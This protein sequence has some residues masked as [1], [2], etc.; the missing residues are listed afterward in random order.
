MQK[1]V[2]SITMSLDGFIA[3]PEISKKQ[4]MGKDGVRLHD[5]IFAGKTDID[6]NLLN[7]V[8]KNSG[9]VIVGARTYNTA[10]EDAWGGE[11]PFTVPAF[12]LCHQLPEIV[13]EGFTF[14]TDGI[15]SGLRQARTAADSKDVWVMGGANIIQQYLKA[16]LVDQL[17]IHI[18]PVLFVNGTRLFD[19]LALEKI[20]L[21]KISTIDTPA[22]THIRYEIVNDTK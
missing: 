7:E 5:W 10:I 6:S 3:G 14:V 21:R 12:V 4:P 13:V 16:K 17:D 9:A 22:A 8:V 19:Q 1:V 2:I 18:A 15:E 20:E 11:S